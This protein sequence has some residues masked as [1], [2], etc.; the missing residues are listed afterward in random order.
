MAKKVT[1]AQGS[2]AGRV[3]FAVCCIWLI[4][5]S[6]AV[7][8][9][10]PQQK[11]WEVL[12]CGLDEQN[13]TRRAAAARALGLLD[14]DSRAIESAKKA[15]GDR[16]AAVRAEAA[17]ALG[18]L[19]DRTSI[20]RLKAALTDKD[21]RVFYAAADSLILMGDSAGYDAYY[22]RLTGER[23][24][25][26]GMIAEKKKLLADPRAL[27]VLAVGVGIGYAPYATYGWMALGELSRDYVSP[28]RVRALLKLEKDPDPGISKGLLTAASDKHWTVRAAALSAIARHGDVRLIGPITPCMADKKAAVRYTAAAAILRLSALRPTDDTPQ[29]VDEK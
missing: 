22:Q 25:G 28:M 13:T 24:S 20:I 26:E 14:G 3:L 4:F 5:S 10:S 8:A 7:L 15:L 17:T 2:R 21:N 6:N 16:K 29:S 18:Q 19:A 1:V 11:A 9:Q 12:Q 27:T 23:K